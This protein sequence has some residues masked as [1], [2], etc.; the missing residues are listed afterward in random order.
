[1]KVQAQSLS[2]L[3]ALHNFILGHDE[4]DLDRWIIDEQAEDSSQGVR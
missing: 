3:V 1:M 2:A 4:T